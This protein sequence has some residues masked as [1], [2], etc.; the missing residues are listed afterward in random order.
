ML[1]PFGIEGSLIYA[2]SRGI[3]AQLK[4]KGDAQINIDLRPRSNSDELLTLLMKKRSK[5][6]RKNQLRKCLKLNSSE[7]LLIS[8]VLAQKNTR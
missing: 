4:S 7:Y 5:D 1:T 8:E 6:S 3:Q 2:H